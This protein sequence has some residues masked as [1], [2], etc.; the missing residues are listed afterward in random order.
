VADPSAPAARPPRLRTDAERV[1]RTDVYRVRLYDGE[2]VLGTFT[3]EAADGHE[4]EAA[5]RRLRSD[6]LSGRLGAET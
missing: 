3:V 5:C 1:G 6:H 4:L 2:R